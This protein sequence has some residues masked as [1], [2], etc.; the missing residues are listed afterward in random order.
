MIEAAIVGCG[1]I[2]PTHAKALELDGRAR[3]RWACDTDPATKDRVTAERFTTRLEDVLADPQVQVV[4]IC[5][6]HQIHADQA[7]AAL[8]AGKHVVCE[9]ALATTP[10][11]I[12]RMVAAA[13]AKPQLVASGIFQ[14]RFSPLSRRLT[15]LL[16]GGDF[17]RIERI[18][19]TF[20]CTRTAAYYA[21][22]PWRGKWAG[23]GGGLLINQAIHT[24]DTALGFLGL[25]TSV[26]A[27]IARKRLTTVE[28]EDSAKLTV[29]G[30][31]GAVL[32]FSAENDQ[33]TGWENRITVTASGGSFTLRTDEHLAELDHPSTALL[34]ELW[35]LEKLDLKGVSLPGKSCYGDQHAWQIQDCLSAIGAGRKPRVDFATAAIPN[36]VVLAAYHSAANRG[37]P[38]ALA[39]LDRVAFTRPTLTNAPAS[40]AR[41]V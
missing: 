17:G 27:E 10:A 29:T 7:V 40:N 23:E 13:A 9:K 37:A 39:D 14:H 20:A 26:A 30:A 18:T 6:P 4:H 1:V 12:T 24:L 25:P 22:G 36:R 8:A 11:D 5:T 21:S 28:V 16:H 34:T 19:T 2:A 15:E 41:G 33:V 32:D 3:I 38:V 35:A 31:N